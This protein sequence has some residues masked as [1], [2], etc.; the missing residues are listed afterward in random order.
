MRLTF[1]QIE[2]IWES[3][4]NETQV[5]INTADPDDLCEA[6]VIILDSSEDQIDSFMVSVDGE[7]KR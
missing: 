7:I 5:V 6:K 1:E 4:T 3:S 2:S